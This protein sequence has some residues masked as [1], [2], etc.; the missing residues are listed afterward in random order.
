MTVQVFVTDFLTEYFASTIFRVDQSMTIEVV[1]L[2]KTEELS[3]EFEEFQRRKTIHTLVW[4][5]KGVSIFFVLQN[6][7]KTSVLPGTKHV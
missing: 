4:N 6:N 7:I 5:K 2:G 1:F 3:A